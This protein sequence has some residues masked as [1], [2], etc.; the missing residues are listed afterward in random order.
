MKQLANYQI[1]NDQEGRQ[2]FVLVPC[3]E[4]FREQEYR[5][6]KHI[7]RE[8]I[9]KTIAGVSLLRAWR[10]HL[11]LTQVE[12]ARR[13]GLTQGGYGHIEATKHPRKATLEKAATALGIT[14]EQLED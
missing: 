4:F 3:S 9:N 11:K 5:Q 13:M 1:I 14:V 10:E 2:A 12:M 8:V 6:K 7:P